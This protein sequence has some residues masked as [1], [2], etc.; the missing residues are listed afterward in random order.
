MIPELDCHFSLKR[1]LFNL[2]VTLKI[3]MG[4]ITAIFGASGSGKTSFLRC[5]A[6]LERADRGYLRMGGHVWQDEEN[7]IFVPPFRRSLAMVF[8]E[9]R[10]FDHLNVAGNLDFAWKRA[11]SSRKRWGKQEIIDILELG[12]LLQRRCHEL[13]GGERQRVAIARSLLTAPEWLVMDEPLA[14]VDG[15]AKQRILGYIR[16]L[17]HRFQLPVLYV[18]HDMGEIMQLADDLILL[19]KGQ[20]LAQGPLRQLTT[21]L[22]LPLAHARDAG[23]LVE[24]TVIALEESYHLTLLHFA[25]GLELRMPHIRSMD[26]ANLAIGTTV[27]VR[28][29]ARDVSLTR[30][31]PG[32]TSILNVFPA[33]VVAIYDESP[34]Q[35]MVKLDISGVFIL[36]LV[37]AYSCS[38]LELRPGLSL[39]VQVKSVALQH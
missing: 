27:R 25:H 32:R 18:S 34:A 30:D 29:L 24:A 37:T 13:S 14:S 15:G 6:G 28:I 39:F 9:G 22:D 12:S 21:R 1:A 31:A 4:G 36:A 20:V 11:P 33:T 23:A 19:E 38:M 17:H 10:L 3:N 5:L 2:D 8:Q 16:Q 35:R 7:A 26:R